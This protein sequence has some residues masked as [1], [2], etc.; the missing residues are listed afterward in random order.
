[1]YP[2]ILELQSKLKRSGSG[3]SLL[4]DPVRKKWISESPEEI[5]RQCLILWLA[6]TFGIPYGRMAVEKQIQV[7]GLMK[8]FDLV[9]YNKHALPY[10]LIECK[11]PQ[12]PLHQNL[13]D[14]A[15]L[16]N[17]KLQAPYLMISNGMDTQVCKIDFINQR[18]EFIKSLPHYPF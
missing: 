6:V 5:V 1:M 4:F 13:L 11:S 12:I 9:I 8:R 15:A 3:K 14:Q 18:Y 17:M 2:T 16:Y 7:L 10:I